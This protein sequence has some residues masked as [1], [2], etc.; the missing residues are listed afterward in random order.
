[1]N[2]HQCRPCHLLHHRRKHHHHLINDNNHSTSLRHL[3]S[4]LSIGSYSDCTAVLYI[5]YLYFLLPGISWLLLEL[6]SGVVLCLTFPLQPLSE[7]CAFVH[8]PILHDS[9][10]WLRLISVFGTQEVVF[11]HFHC[12][13]NATRPMSP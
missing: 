11:L 5:S 1:M 7:T 6:S 13:Y 2:I 4:G 12:P 10:P 8:S 9:S 3:C